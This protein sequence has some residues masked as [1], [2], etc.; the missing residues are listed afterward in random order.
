MTPFCRP[1]AHACSMVA[2]VVLT[3]TGCYNTY[4]IDKTELQKLES[5]VEQPEVVTVYGDCSGPSQASLAGGTKYW[6]Q[7]DTDLPEEET[8]PEEEPPM[9]DSDATATDAQAP[10]E[11]TP[12]AEA[13]AP[14][15]PGCESVP[16][17]TANGVTVLTT[18]D[19]EHR[20]TPFNFIMSAGQLVSPEYDLLLGLDNVEGAEVKEFSTLKTVI[21]VVGV[22]A[23]TVGTFVAISLLAPEGGTFE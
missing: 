9:A 22:T 6:A 17:S 12:E 15:R 3:Q 7:A 14:S 5:S 16:V 4:F 20:V 19:Q 11:V 18:D 1:L 23:V 2:L 21:A 13:A 10:G 8:A